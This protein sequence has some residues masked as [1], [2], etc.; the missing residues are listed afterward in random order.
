MSASHNIM[1]EKQSGIFNN[2][3]I[4][5]IGRN[6][7]E[8]SEPN[9]GRPK[10]GTVSQ[11]RHYVPHEVTV[12]AS[13]KI[14]ALTYP[15]NFKVEPRAKFDD[16]IQ[17]NPSS[18]ITKIRDPRLNRH[19][20]KIGDSR[21]QNPKTDASLL[22]SERSNEAINRARS[23]G[24]KNGFLQYT[25]MPT[26]FGVESSFSQNGASGVI[27]TSN[28]WGKSPG[29]GQH[30]L[31]TV[32][33][34]T[35]DINQNFKWGEPL[36][37]QSKHVSQSNP[38]PAQKTKIIGPEYMVSDGGMPKEVP[39]ID[40][41]KDEDS[42]TLSD[43]RQ[44]VKIAAQKGDF[45]TADKLI[46]IH[47]FLAPS[48]PIKSGRPRIEMTPSSPKPSI[49]SAAVIPG[50]AFQHGGL[51]FATGVTASL[52]TVGLTPHYHELFKKLSGKVPLTIFNKNWLRLAHADLATQPQ[53]MDKNGNLIYRSFP[54]EPERSMPLHD[55]ESNINYMI[56]LARDTYKFEP[57]A[58]G[59][60]V[61]R[62]TVKDIAKEHGWPTA[63]RYC[64]KVR[65][66]VFTFKVG[67][68]GKD[69][70][71]ISVWRKDL[72]DLARQ[73]SEAAGD[74]DFHDNPYRRGGEKEG[75]DYST[76]KPR[77]NQLKPSRGVRAGSSGSSN[78]ANVAQNGGGGKTKRHKLCTAPVNHPYKGRSFD[79]NYRGPM[80]KMGIKDNQ[81][82]KDT[83]HKGSRDASQG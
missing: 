61:H 19:K 77:E 60:A 36:I 42:N 23:T 45:D 78:M 12:P 56:T 10:T 7:L 63:F 28:P 39:V 73:E 38:G 71:D 50:P 27:D 5:T 2:S 21:V 8:S 51:S 18:S 72:E 57:F 62:E 81:D 6:Y 1:L 75:Y 34:G 11:Q 68:E 58:N 37:N 82:D 59:L 4:N 76:G 54:Y 3:N 74:I 31:P 29:F 79:P 22:A 66:S 44:R 32:L 46:R 16:G 47:Q 48:S 55:W 17:P 70:Q 14:A 26:P 67:P 69:T 41:T 30:A 52:E 83:G 35:T 15:I 64:Q 13:Q 40:L 80:K 20:E 49:L 53:K 25:E 24:I 33:S 9:N 65:H 43:L